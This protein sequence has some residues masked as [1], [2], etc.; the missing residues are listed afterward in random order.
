MI[1]EALTVLKDIDRAPAEAATD[2]T[3]GAAVR[4][5]DPSRQHR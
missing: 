5:I 2:V 4:P 1:A 3:G